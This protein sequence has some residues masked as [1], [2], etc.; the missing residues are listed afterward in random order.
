MGWFGPLFAGLA[1][2]TT[3]PIPSR[4]CGESR[5]LERSLVW[6]PLIG[7]LIGGLIAGFD[8]GVSTLLPVL[9]A[10]V[11]SVIAMVAISGALHLD[12]LADTA[13][14]FLSSRP[15]ERI[16]EIMRDSRV[17]PM[18][19]LA[20]VGVLLL[21]VAAVA[22]L[23]PPVRF[24]TLLLLPLAGRTAPVLIMSTLAYVRA[25]GLGTVFQRK[26]TL[27]APLLALA[28]LTTAGFFAAGI[29]GLVAAAAAV[30]GTAIFA[31]WCRAKIGGYTGDTLGA[32][33]ELAEVVP[34]LV[35]L[36]FI[37]RGGLV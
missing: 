26:R 21:K 12:G 24:G 4:W 1:F 27:F 35:V 32:A 28:S 22:S 10:S 11:L 37:Q 17:G 19:V 36:M 25:Q 18:G 9:P 7:L 15:R 30:G 5:D 13:D 2:L 6:F 31:L 3:L 8:A 14:G 20:I 33:C 23:P 29:A 16:L 34:A